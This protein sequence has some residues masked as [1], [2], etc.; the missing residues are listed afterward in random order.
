MFI[1][2]QSDTY[3]WPVVVKLPVSGGKY[4]E[5]TFE[6]EFKRLPQARLKQL[7]NGMHDETI[8]SIELSREVMVGWKG[9]AVDASGSELPYTEEAR[10]RL[11]EKALV[12]AAVAQAFIS[13]V[14]GATAKN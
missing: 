14:A 10:D 2:N 13:S 6:A 8:S 5:S 1:L 7:W 4:Q 11:L 3:F 12:A 9:V